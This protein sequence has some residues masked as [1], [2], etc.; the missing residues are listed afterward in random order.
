MGWLHKKTST[1]FLV[2]NSCCFL[3][4]HKYE[5]RQ[6]GRCCCSLSGF[7]FF[8]PKHL[9]S[10]STVNHCRF[11][12]PPKKKKH[13][14][15]G[16]GLETRRAGSA[17]DGETDGLKYCSLYLGFFNLSDSDIWES[18]TPKGS[19]WGWHTAFKLPKPSWLLWWV[20]YLQMSPESCVWAL[21]VI[22]HSTL[23]AT[24]VRL[25]SVFMCLYASGGRTAG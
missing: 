25:V 3:S 7:C 13:S 24:G 15:F 20:G 14:L 6:G 11:K 23:V 12:P 16:C 19:A 21:S 10:F 22:Q 18:P 2:G 9:D 1:W 8:S 5:I 4:L 17:D